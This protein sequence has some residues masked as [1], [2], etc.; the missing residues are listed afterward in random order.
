VPY[1]ANL[2]KFRVAMIATSSSR[3]TDDD[4]VAVINQ[5]RYISLTADG[6]EYLTLTLTTEKYRLLWRQLG[7]DFAR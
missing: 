3:A 6:A 2:S 1:E 4:A 5:F 7:A